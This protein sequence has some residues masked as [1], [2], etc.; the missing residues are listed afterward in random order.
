MYHIEQLNWFT[1]DYNI[2]LNWE[3]KHNFTVQICVEYL[4]FYKLFIIDV[5]FVLFFLKKKIEYYVCISKVI[6][7][8]NEYST[9][10]VFSKDSKS[11]YSCPEKAFNF[12]TI[13][14]KC[15]NLVIK[16]NCYDHSDK[17]EDG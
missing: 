9:Y 12:K 1:K 14:A 7:N 4:Y 16:L 11:S 15:L 13:V 10:G 5:F 2:E 6:N 17:L 8:P 3:V